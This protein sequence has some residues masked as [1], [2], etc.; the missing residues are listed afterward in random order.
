MLLQAATRIQ[1]SGGTGITPT[2]PSPANA[3]SMALT[4]ALHTQVS[5]RHAGAA[6]GYTAVTRPA[7]RP[8]L[9]QP[10]RNMCNT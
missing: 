6:I 2:S 3:T 10:K 1:T 8:L 5:T 4:P 7:N 9:T